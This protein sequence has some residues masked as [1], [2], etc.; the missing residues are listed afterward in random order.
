MDTPPGIAV[1]HRVMNQMYHP[2]ARTACGIMLN[3]WVTRNTR[4]SLVG[5]D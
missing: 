3:S 4:R 2:M 1:R 5:A